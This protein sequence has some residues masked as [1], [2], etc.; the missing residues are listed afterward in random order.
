MIS[1]KEIKWFIAQIFLKSKTLSLSQLQFTS[2]YRELIVMDTVYNE[3]P[4]RLQRS[5]QFIL[6]M[7]LLSSIIH[8]IQFLM[9]EAVRNSFYETHIIF[10]CIIRQLLCIKYVY[11]AGN[12]NHRRNYF[13][14][15]VRVIKWFQLKCISNQF[16]GNW[17]IHQHFTS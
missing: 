11:E 16:L 17:N 14:A 2:R 13:R 12:K 1:C 10:L 7:I 4:K 15:F 8:S 6:C 3:Q 5:R 9:H